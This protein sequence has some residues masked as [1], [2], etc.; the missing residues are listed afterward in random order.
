MRWSVMWL[1]GLTLLASC[2][3]GGAGID[4]CG[5]WRPI[6]VSRAD[7]L[8]DGTARQILAHNETGARLCGW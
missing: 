7:T 5:A 1:V 3:S 6:L 2:A 4:S 8:T